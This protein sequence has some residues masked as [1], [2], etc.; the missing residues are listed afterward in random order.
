MRKGDSSLDPSLRS[1]LRLGMTVSCLGYWG[2]GE[3]TS[4]ARPSPSL[5]KR[6]VSFLTNP[7]KRGFC[8]FWTLVPQ[9]RCRAKALNASDF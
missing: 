6:L 7:A 2:M 4:S 9:K 5:P 3:R 8:F 1:G